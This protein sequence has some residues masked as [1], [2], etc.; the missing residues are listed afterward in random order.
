MRSIVV[1][2]PVFGLA[3]A[4][5]E[6]GH[7]QSRPE[8]WTATSAHDSVFHSRS[9]API[10]NTEADSS[11]RAS[12][13]TEFTIGV[14]HRVLPHGDKPAPTVSVLMRGRSDRWVGGVAYAR[15]SS[16]SSVCCGPNP[17][18]TYQE[19]VVSLIVGREFTVSSQMP[20]VALD[21]RYEP[22]LYNSIRR[23]SQAD[24]HPPPTGWHR[25]PWIVSAGA[26]V[27]GRISPDLHGSI[28]ARARAN[29]DSLPLGGRTRPVFEFSAGVGW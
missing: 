24:F 19:Q 5:A 6:R 15:E 17:G 23:G 4:V 22:S 9:P 3:L 8:G 1:L 20:G 16:P 14:A 21:L 2:L 12:P 29:M 10:A 27:R 11:V 13:R 25:A 26:S 28:T 18:F 7:G